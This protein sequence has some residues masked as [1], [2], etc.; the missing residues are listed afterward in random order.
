MINSLYELEPQLIH[1]PLG[2]TIFGSFEFDLMVES[3]EVIVEIEILSDE[4]VTRNYH[5]IE[6]Y[7]LP[8]RGESN[9]SILITLD[10]I[11]KHI[12][13]LKDEMKLNEIY[14]TVLAETARTGAI[15]RYLEH[16]DKFILH[17]ITKGYS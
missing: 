8:V 14:F 12:T 6:V 15:I 16:A 2:S 13:N 4:K 5:K 10:E 3:L 11:K 1:L 17:G 9:G 7:D